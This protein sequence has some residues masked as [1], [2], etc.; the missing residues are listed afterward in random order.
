MSTP[1]SGFFGPGTY[2]AFAIA[3][4]VMALSAIGMGRAISFYGY[5]LQKKPVEAPRSLS[6]IPT[7]TDGWIRVGTDRIEP[8]EVAEALGTQNYVTR[9]YVQRDLPEGQEPVVL[10]FHAAYY[11][12]MIDT[13]PHVPERCFVGG[14]LVQTEFAETLDLPMDTSSW[15]LDPSVPEDLAGES[16]TLYRVR[17]P[18]NDAERGIVSS[19]PGGTVRL[20]RDVTPE[21]PLRMRTSSYVAGGGRQLFAGYF[22][23]ANGGTV[24]SAEGVRTLAFDLTS[25]YAYYLKVQVTSS[26]VESAE[27]LAQYAGDL[28]GE[29]LGEIMLCVPDWVELRQSSVEDEAAE[30][31]E[32][33]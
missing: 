30:A 26:N 13:V 18:F 21:R 9:I 6:T 2:V 8:P 29:L 4:G 12:G 20:P 33:D 17:M 1:R 25:D 5:H 27:E 16:G 23:V 15:R 22:F 3:V 32:Q 31:G 28:V 19:R 14:G 7:S 24:A 10:D 11:T